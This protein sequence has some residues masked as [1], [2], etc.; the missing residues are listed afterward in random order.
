MPGCHTGLC[1][2]YCPC[3]VWMRGIPSC[4]PGKPSFAPFF[5]VLHPQGGSDPSAWHGGCCSEH[6]GWGLHI[7][8]HQGH[9]LSHR[10]THV[11]TSVTS[12]VWVPPKVLLGTNHLCAPAP[13]SQTHVNFPSDPDG[14]FFPVSTQLYAPSAIFGWCSLSLYFPFFFVDVFG[15][16]QGMFSES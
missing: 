9:L 2:F 11:P 12:H 10:A 6:P 3:N 15:W 13:Q 16:Y 4:A 1:P 8:P 14:V 5:K 7:P